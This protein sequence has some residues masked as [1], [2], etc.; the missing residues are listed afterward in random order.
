MTFLEPADR[1]N[2]AAARHFAEHE[3]GAVIGEDAGMLLVASIYPYVRS[4][5]Y[6]AAR[7]FERGVP[8]E[9]SVAAVQ[10]FGA[11]H[12]QQLNLWTSVDGDRDLIAAAEAAGMVRGIELE[13][14]AIAVAPALPEAGPGPGIELVEVRDEQQ[15]D[16]YAAVQSA[17]RIEAGQDPDSVRHFAS[18]AVLLDP[19][20]HAFVAYLDGSPAACA[21]T[22]RHEDSAGLF[23][24]ATK[25][26]ARNRGLGALVSSAATRA[27]FQSGA[28]SVT[29]TATALGAPV[30]R[31][32]GFEQFSTRVRYGH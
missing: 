31:R 32:L 17:L 29:L 25:T 10:S 16:A 7:R 9:K 12:G 3:D 8:A 19:R 1:T 18:P 6:S 27:A 28:R 26:E 20:V 5:F 23:W 13:D 24:V 14:M 4:L 22:F 30:Y 15:A 21:M 11:E 2:L